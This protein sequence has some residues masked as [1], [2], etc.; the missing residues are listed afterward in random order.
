MI[1]NNMDLYANGMQT[2]SQH[3]CQNSSQINANTGSGK[4]HYD[5]QT[6][7]LCVK[8]CE[9]IVN[10]M[11]FEGL[12]GCVRDHTNKHKAFIPILYLDR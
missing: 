12:T 8:T 6:S 1:P 7:Y 11:F 3:R 4:D 5:N 2:W 9:L 10:T